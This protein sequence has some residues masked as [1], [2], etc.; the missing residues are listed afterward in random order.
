MRSEAGV[1]CA[2]GDSLENIVSLTR[3][4]S[5]DEKG[6]KEATY[7]A[8]DGLGCTP[9][10]SVK[11][12]LIK[13]N[14]CYYWDYSTGETTDPRLVS[15]IID[16]IREKWSKKA[17]ITIAESDASAMQTKHSFKMLGYEALAK[18]K[19]V[20]LLNLS[21]DETCPRE[22]NVGKTKLVLNLPCSVLN[23]D[24]LINVPKLKV[25]PYAGGQSLHIT[26]A[27]KNLFGCVPEPRKVK[28]HPFLPKVI[29][30]VSK[31]IKPNMTIVDGIVALGKHPI[32]LGLII[33]GTDN[34]AVDFVCARL[35]GYN[36]WRIN[37]LSL[38]AK[39]NVGNV[40]NLK[41][42][43]ENMR[44]SRKIFPKRNRFIFK[45]SWALQLSLLHAYTK[46]SGDIVPA[47]LEK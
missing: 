34:L 41:V 4:K 12:F 10:K 19:A 43:G 16:Y 27:L 31:L 44:D 36:P 30:A 17:E 35:I 5:F 45:T 47:V 8:V 18:E 15:S 42:V 40:A 46:A 39:E 20:T 21:T 33:A 25:G 23:S 24:F 14:L 1:R 22:V 6:I 38:A 37:Y 9:S 29:V 7:H 26:C 32:K 13:P 2:R 3:T 28:Y 11:R